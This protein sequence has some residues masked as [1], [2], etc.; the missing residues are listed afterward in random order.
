M[1]RV[2]PSVTKTAFS[3]PH[4]DALTTQ[5]WHDCF[6][7]RK[8]KDEL[9]FVVDQQWLEE[10]LTRKYPEDLDKEAMFEWARKKARGL[11]Y[12]SSDGK[13]GRSLV[14]VW[15]SLCYNCNEVALWVNDRLIHPVTGTAP[16][17][18]SDLPADIRA[19]YNEA[20]AI[21]ALSPRGAAA[22]LRLAIQKLCKEL[23]QPGKDLNTDIRSLVAKGLPSKVQQALDTVRVIGNN[24]VHPGAIDLRDDR[25][26]AETLFRL[27]N[28]I[29]EKLISEPKHIDEMYG[30][31]PSGALKAIEA[32]DGVSTN[33]NEADG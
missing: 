9:P 21:L 2:P 13:Y 1:S 28:L 19:D 16:E 25:A 29:A 5:Y 30:G 4:C 31:L 6:A 18:N 7:E 33:E 14:N 26:T 3:C 10:V 15:A 20:S 32:R 23:G 22:L 11:P 17:A 24:A 27:V 8:K 12:L